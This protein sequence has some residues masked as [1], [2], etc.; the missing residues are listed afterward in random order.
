M[1]DFPT[2]REDVVSWGRRS[3]VHCPDY[4]AVVNPKTGDTFSIVSNNY[5]LVKHEEALETVIDA[6]DSHQEFGKYEVDTQ[7]LNNGA[8]MKTKIRFPEVEYDI[9]GGDLINPTIEVKNSYDAGWQYEIRFG[10]FRLVCSNGLVIGKQFVHYLKRHTQSLD[11]EKV[12]Q[13]LI[14]G[15][16]EFS[17]Q[18][19]L[20]KTW[21]DQVTTAT[22]Y[23]QVM[24][25]MDFSKKDSEAIHEEV[26]ANSNIIQ[27]NL[28]RKTL[29]KWVLYNILTAYVT[30]QVQSEI[31]RTNL[32]SKLRRVF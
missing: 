32:E 24:T 9:G 7:L 15:M 4:K 3:R 2:V 31:R 22:E 19:E 30:H 6:V 23:E 21:V 20:W 27:D 1:T 28:K 26:E 18:T 14:A 12:K 17:E 10:A 16:E 13:V 8:K 29:S 25:E 5:K 11:Q